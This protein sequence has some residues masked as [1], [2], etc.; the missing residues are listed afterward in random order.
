M[1]TVDHDS[2]GFKGT[3]TVNKMRCGSALMVAC[4]CLAA[5]IGSGSAHA[6]SKIVGGEPAPAGAFPF[7][8]FVAQFDA[9]GNAVG[10]CTGDLIAPTVVLTAAHCVVDDYGVVPPDQMLA[11]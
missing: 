2:D 6:T 5:L 7:A 4:V 10:L 3:A 1:R 9:A 8:V 11:W